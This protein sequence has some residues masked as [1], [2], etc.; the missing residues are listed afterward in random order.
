M[1]RRRDIGETQNRS[2]GLFP[3]Q[4]SGAFAPG[5]S[6]SSMRPFSFDARYA[7]LD[8]SRQIPYPL[9][10][11]NPTPPSVHRSSKARR[12]SC[13]IHYS[14][15][16]AS[17]LYVLLRQSC[18]RWRESCAAADIDCIVIVQS[19]VKMGSAQR[20]YYCVYRRIFAAT[21]NFISFRAV[22]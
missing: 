21:G 2:G 10:S 16:K 6:S 19:Y 7:S 15:A 12:E 18:L 22:N 3:Q 5:S 11:T 1:V 9:N 14:Y 4:L 20:S 13:Q 8:P 17:H